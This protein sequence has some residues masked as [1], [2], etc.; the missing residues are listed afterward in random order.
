VT[1]AVSA[2]EAAWSDFE[3]LS[4]APILEAMEKERA[5]VADFFTDTDIDQLKE[6]IADLSLPLAL[7]ERE[8]ELQRREERRL[9]EAKRAL[10]EAVEEENNAEEAME[11]ETTL[12][13][14]APAKKEITD[15]QPSEAVRVWMHVSG[16]ADA[17]FFLTLVEW[18]ARATGN[19]LFLG[20][21]ARAIAF[22]REHHHDDLQ[23]AVLVYTIVNQ[24][25]EDFRRGIYH[26]FFTGKSDDFVQHKETT[27]YVSRI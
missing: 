13:N 11:K 24:G 8:Q 5:E 25:L 20:W 10:E 21:M 19:R 2:I 16:M 26:V 14:A 12:D 18:R 22:V 17:D 3:H 4:L 7:E 1:V 27:D 6:R 9:E 23:L 15:E